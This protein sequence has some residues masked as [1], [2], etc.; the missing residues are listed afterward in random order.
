MLKKRW[1]LTIVLFVLGIAGA[2]RGSVQSVRVYLNYKDIVYQCESNL[3]EYL[4]DEWFTLEEDVFLQKTLYEMRRGQE[5]LTY[6]KL[7]KERYSEFCYELA[8]GYFYFYEGTQGRKMA[9]FWFQEALNCGENMSLGKRN[10]GNLY[11]KISAK[12]QILYEDLSELNE[13]EVEEMDDEKE[14]YYL[15]REIVGWISEYA[16]SFI[17]QESVTS[18]EL[19]LEV[20]RIEE[21]ISQISNIEE[22]DTLRIM[23]EDAYRNIELAAKRIGQEEQ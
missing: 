1:V 9:S 8:I 6:L 15:Y 19:R 20:R 22:K 4:E 18:Y 2:I 14:A 10:R 21:R 11:R 3:E 7:N 16:Y 13:Y 23:I 17:K 12:D 5:N